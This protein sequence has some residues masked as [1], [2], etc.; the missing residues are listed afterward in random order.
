MVGLR[1]FQGK[2]VLNETFY[3][4]MGNEIFAK[5]CENFVESSPE[6]VTFEFY[7]GE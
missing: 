2:C 7:F 5:M 1:I 4:S 6:K 3:S